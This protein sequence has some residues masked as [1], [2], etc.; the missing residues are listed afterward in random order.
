MDKQLLLFPTFEEK[1]LMTALIEAIKVLN[2]SELISRV[3]IL[4]AGDP[5]FHVRILWHGSGFLKEER[6]L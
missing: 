3:V 5:F 4:D 6:T 1:E 2:S